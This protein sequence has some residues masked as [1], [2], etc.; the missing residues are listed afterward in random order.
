MR[1]VAVQTS[2]NISFNKVPT[3]Y[4]RFQCTKC[5]Y[6]T[7]TAEKLSYHLSVCDGSIEPTTD[8]DT[9]E[10]NVCMKNFFSK[11]QLN[12]HLTYH[13]SISNLNV[14]VSHR[15]VVDNQQ[16]V[17]FSSN[18]ETM[19]SSTNGVPNTRSTA[20]NKFLEFKCLYCKVACRSK[21]TRINHIK[22]HHPNQVVVEN[23]SSKLPTTPCQWCDKVITKRNLL[24]HIKSK[25]PNVKPFDC[26]FCSMKF[27]L[28]CGKKVHISKCHATN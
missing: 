25:H 10:C 28:L 26:T 7:K 18:Q 8:T 4:K 27:K 14:Q 23:N 24:R 22:S 20:L 9:N 19:N 11:G 21:R 2:S 13:N 5:I 12:K 1:P 15:N 3:T 17:G 6:K 16:P